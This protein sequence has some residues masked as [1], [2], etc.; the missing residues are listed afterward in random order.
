MKKI[1]FL[2]LFPLWLYS[3]A[4]EN[5]IKSFVSVKSVKPDSSVYES[6]T[7]PKS[8]K[9]CGG[10]NVTWTEEVTYADE[11]RVCS[12]STLT[13]KSEVGFV[14]DGKLIVERGGN[15]VIDGGTVT[16]QDTMLWKGI[17]VWG[18]KSMPPDSILAHGKVELKNGAIVEYAQTGIATIKMSESQGGG[19]GGGEGEI[20]PTPDYAYAGGR[21]VAY[22]SSIIRNC[23]TGVKFYPYD[24]DQTSGFT[25]VTFAT[26]DTLL[27][28]GEDFNAGV[29]LNRVKGIAFKGCIFK[30]TR[31]TGEV[32]QN[33]RGIGIYSFDSEFDVMEYCN[34]ISSPCP[35]EYIQPCRFRKL[36]YGIKALNSLTTST[37]TVDTAVFDNNVRALYA[38]AV[39]DITVTRSR[40][41]LGNSFDGARGIYLDECTGYTIEENEFIEEGNETIG[42]VVN[43]SGGDLNEIYLNRFVDTK[44]GIL[45]QNE[46]RATDGTGLQIKCNEFVDNGYDLAVTHNLPQMTKLTGIAK[47]Q[48]SSDTLPDA[49]AG[50]RFSWTG[51]TGVPTDINNGA[52]HVTYYYHSNAPTY[53]QLQP[54]YYTTSTVT[55]EPNYLA[56][57]NPDQSCPSHIDTTGG[58][59]HGESE[60]KGMMAA[61]E[62]SADSIG[63]LIEA[64]EDAG[65]TESLEWEVGLSTP[66]Q[67]LE[68][69]NE[70]M[71]A[72]PWVS[73][74]VMATAIEKESVLAD[75]MIRDVMVANPESAKDD[76]LLQKLEER[77]NPVPEYMLGQIL[78]GRGLVSVYG[79]LMARQ[80]YYR[81]QKAQALKR[82]KHWYKKDTLNPTASVDSLMKLL[83]QE[84]TL[85]A[86]YG[87][88]FI[89]AL[90]G[91]W[92][93][94][95]DVL[96]SIPLQFNLSGDELAAHTDMTGYFELLE[97][98]NG[99]E[100]DSLQVVSLY[101]M[102]LASEGR[103]GVYA[104]NTLLV[105]GEMEYEEPILYPNLE[106][107]AQ[108]DLEYETLINTAINKK[109]MEVFP[110]PAN[111]YII[112]KWE[113][114]KAA[115][116]LLIRLGN[117]HGQAVLEMEAAGRQ[118]QQLVKTGQLEAGVYVVSLFANGNLVDSE[119]VSIVK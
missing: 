101:N 33:K 11:I 62:T 108:A 107:S 93:L 50:N 118:N 59:G 44:F 41:E 105:L 3:Q 109:Q 60:L 119:K 18:T 102:A 39:D 36:Y 117:S 52:Q 67:S 79:D 43:Q 53:F 35:A 84:H 56:G 40:F 96:D 77:T 29:Y 116:G 94:G 19:G 90:E 97:S 7:L 54:Q 71:G 68:V 66:A 2:L 104:R 88:A 114:E 81:Q 73:D 111:G 46:N 20:E 103:A 113:L 48:G 26:T 91:E 82:L 72:S 65:D 78:Q 22:D 14:P 27:A 87:L 75:A 100:L 106:K 47:Y 28:S 12:G 30:N 34:G 58:G 31:S 85:N 99:A 98:I 8:L 61:L 95:Q 69:Y 4:D 83:R 1:A 24:Y 21:I 42:I 64:L 9:I 37:F 63:Q 80:S 17:E 89:H 45:T 74:T 32:A 70:L 23:V 13:I 92:A 10:E 86:L 112:V 15:L 115:D 110:N 51:P 38:G 16:A 55:I 49:P 25:G 6:F 57:W 76:V 5:L